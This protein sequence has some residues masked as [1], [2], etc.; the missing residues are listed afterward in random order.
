M[1]IRIRSNNVALTLILNL[2]SEVF[3]A[4]TAYYYNQKINLWKN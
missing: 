1:Y 4:I 2:V 3:K